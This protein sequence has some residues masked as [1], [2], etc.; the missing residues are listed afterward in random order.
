MRARPPWWAVVAL[1]AILSVAPAGLARGVDVLFFYQEGCARC[2]QVEEF[3]V[4]L[5]RGGLAF[6]L[7]RYEI[8][9]PDGWSL[10]HRLI[11]A[12][13]AELGPV[14]MVFVGDVGVV[15]NTFYGI[16]PQPVTLTGLRH[17]LALEE[18]IREAQA[19]GAP[20]P[21]TKL[22]PTATE[23]VLFTREEGCP[24]CAAMEARVMRM[25]ERFPAL[26]IQRLDLA[27]ADAVTTFDK[28]KRLYGVQGDP[29]GLFVGDMAVVGGQVFLPRQAPLLLASPEGE[30]AVEEAV[31][32]AVEAGA[33]SPLDRLRLRA[34]LTLGAVVVAALLDSVNPCEFAVLILLLGTLL[35]MGKR[36]KVILSLIHI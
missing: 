10:L 24:G 15:G 17:E 36:V 20:S 12:Y 18:A 21:L 16:G 1:A 14:P 13:G 27:S 22:P 4:D 35:T 25:A 7:H 23:A 29:P 2:K 9:T 34:Q 30:A 33:T 19:A 5:Q 28:L 11:S 32:R 8:R 31:A 3:L 6:I 26:G